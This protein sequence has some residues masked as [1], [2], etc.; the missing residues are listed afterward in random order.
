MKLRDY[1]QEAVQSVYDYFRDNDGNPL[2]VL[3][4]GSGKSY[5]QAAFVR[6]AIEQ[7]PD[8]RIM[9]LTH[10]QELLQQNGAELI[11]SW[12]GACWKL[13]Y[14]SAGLKSRD[15]DKQIIIAGIQSVFRRALEFGAI[16]LVIIDEA[17][18]VPKKGEGMY[19]R[20]IDELRAVNPKLKI[21]GMTAT[22]YRLDSGTLCGGE[23]SIFTDICYD[24]DLIRLIG[25]GYLAPLT[26]KLGE[27]R[28]SLKGVRVRGGEY[29]PGDLD[30]VMNDPGVVGKAIKETVA[31]CADRK[32][33]LIFCSSVAHAERVRNEL[34]TC[35][36]IPT[37]TITGDTPKAERSE[38]IAKFKAGKLRALTNVNVLTTGFNVPDIDAMIVLR[39]TK[40]PGLHVQMMGRGM[41]PFPG[42]VDCLVLDYTNNIL[43]HGPIDKIKVRKKEDGESVVDTEPLRECPNCASLVPIAS[44]QCPECDYEFERDNAPKHKE[45]A[46]IGAEVLS[47][48]SFAGWVEVDS[49]SYHKH[50]KKGKPVSLKVE[51]HC[52]IT[53]YSEWVCLQHRGFPRNKAASWWR[54]RSTNGPVPNT[55]DDALDEVR[56][57]LEPVK[58]MVSITGK[59]PQIIGHVFEEDPAVQAELKDAQD[60]GAPKPWGPW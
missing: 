35:Y 47:V 24:T 5:V 8:Q 42:K 16:H 25:S 6:S 7:Y 36:G 17:H 53:S 21:V 50:E 60:Q 12:P 10:V 39:P 9:L 31:L 3:P 51:Y 15:T 58:I 28:T 56:G 23:G 11:R 59:F 2:I 43:E 40:S 20:F 13:G 1:Q 48:P 14:Y 54:R 27:N 52:G 32:K 33:W 37:E 22:P 18:L 55:V 46:A 29:V 4:T 19:R 45:K 57:L 41:R 30:R 44:R 26:T 34:V 38:T 49:V